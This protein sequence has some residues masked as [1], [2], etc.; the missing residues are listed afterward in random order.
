M[1]EEAGRVQYRGEELRSLL[2]GLGTLGE[3]LQPPP[4]TNLSYRLW[5]LWS[6]EKP[7]SNIRMIVRSKVLGM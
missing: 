4:G 6:K 7:S 2:P 5:N 3:Y 1:Q